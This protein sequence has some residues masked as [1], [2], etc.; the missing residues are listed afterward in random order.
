M[1]FQTPITIAQAIA[2]IQQSRYLLPA[3]QREFVWKHEKIEWLFDSIMRNYPISSFLFWDVQGETKN[4]YKFYQFVREYRQKYKTHNQDFSTKLE[5]FIAVLDGQQRLTS[6]YIGLCGSYAY[7]KKYYKEENTERSYPTRWLYL[8][9]SRKL[10]DEEDGREFE[11]KFLTK[12]DVENSKYEWFQVSKILQFTNFMSFSRFLR[13]ENINENDPAFNILANLQESIHNKPI[14]NY[15]LETDQKID[16]VLNIFIRINSGGEPLDFSDILM[17]IAVANWEEKDARKEIHGLT[18]NV[19]E[20]GF[21]IS[22]DFI[23]KSFL[24]LHSRDIKFRVTNFSKSNAKTFEEKWD[25]IRD[26]I[27]ST[28]DL[29]KTFG[30]TDQTLV[31]KNALIPVVY[32]LYHR[33]IAKGFDTKKCYLEDRKE[34][35]RWLHTVLVKRLFGGASDNVLGQVRGAF[36]NNV[37]DIPL[38]NG[39]D[40][41]PANSINKEIRRDTGISDEFI[42]ELLLTQKDDQYAFSLLALLFPNLDYENNNFHK[43]HLHPLAEYNEE[44]HDWFVYNSLKNLQMLDANE[45]MSKKDKNLKKWVEEETKDKATFYSRH[46]LPDISLELEN[47][48]EFITERT[49]ILEKRLKEVLV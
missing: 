4:D 39:I 45:N 26:T 25:K 30:F 44:K 38:E 33:G 46:L 2:N 31:S 23:L 35:E 9:I 37:I 20:K 49:K 7:K 8:N 29:I 13:E 16:K 36:T 14:I 11:F 41:F 22:K 27:L 42:E 10:H 28:F 21:T 40:D 5:N 18:D 32:Y 24:Y 12:E 15:F 1:A 17:S 6:L 19:R 47:F 3:I 34:I 48:D 43:D